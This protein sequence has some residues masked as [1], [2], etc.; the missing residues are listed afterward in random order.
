LGNFAMF[1]VMR[2]GSSSVLSFTNRRID[3]EL[4]AR[5]TSVTLVYGLCQAYDGISH[6]PT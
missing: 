5:K 2:L 6:D 3:T 1:T 4:W